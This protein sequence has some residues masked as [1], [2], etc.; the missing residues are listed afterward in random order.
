ME[1]QKNPKSIFRKEV[2]ILFLISKALTILLLLFFYNG[3][4]SLHSFN[5]WNR[6]YNPDGH[7]SLFLPFANWDGQHYLLLTDWG[8]NL[9]QDSSAFFPLFP[10]SIQLVN[11]IFN[12]A[13]LSAF[14]LNLAFSYLFLG[15]FYN[16]AIQYIEKEKVVKSMILIVCFPASFFL[17]VFYAEAMFLFLIFAFLYYYDSRKS[18]WS[19]LF[20]F[21]LPL[22]KGQ[23]FY[24]LLSMLILLIV[25]LFKREK[26][27]IK[28]EAYNLVAFFVG[29]IAYLAFFYFATGNPLSGIQAQNNFV[30]NLKLEHAINIPRF[31]EYLFSPSQ[32]IFAYE[33]SLID[34]LFIMIALVLIIFASQSKR[35]VWFVFY[36][37]LSYPIAALG[38]GGSFTRFS[39]MLAPFFCLA[40]F[41]CRDMNKY[42]FGLVCTL[43]LLL[44]IVFIYRFSLNLWVG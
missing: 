1:I 32:A 39:L 3:N 35:T 24:V 5:L 40:Y 33:N 10:T 31:V 23:A 26:I 29:G 18:Y 38:T 16:Y 12:N 2:F 37:M 17:T 6:W 28:Y 4:E 19:L 13:Y 34:K 7:P 11:L 41:S 8:Y 44:Q 14:L 30:F 43:M 42:V 15:Y 21:L 27:N 25:K 20:A 36:L 22:T 9:F